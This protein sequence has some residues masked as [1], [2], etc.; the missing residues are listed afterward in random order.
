MMHGIVAQA[1]AFLLA[2]YSIGHYRNCMLSGGALIPAGTLMQFFGKQI[3]CKGI[4]NSNRGV[5]YL[6]LNKWDNYSLNG[7]VSD[8]LL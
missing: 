5:G 4:N 7:W 8:L 2:F 3:W 1:Q 6:W